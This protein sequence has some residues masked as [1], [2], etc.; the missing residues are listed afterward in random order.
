MV[1]NVAQ[2][3]AGLDEAPAADLPVL[4]VLPMLP[5]MLPMLIAESG[6]ERAAFGTGGALA[7]PLLERLARAR[8]RLG[9]ERLEAPVLVAGLLAQPAG[10]QEELIRRDPRL[11][12]WG[13]GELLLRRGEE[14]AA[15]DPAES[16]RLAGLALTTADQLDGCHPE[17]VLQDLRARAWAAVG[18]ARRQAG[19]L[20]AAEEA[21]RASAGC[22]AHGTGD[23]LVE[24]RLLEFEAAVRLDQERRGEAAALLL[25]AASRYRSVNEPELLDRVLLRRNEIRR[26]EE[27]VRFATE[28]VFEPSV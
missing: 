10:W 28:L 26:E 11:Q 1:D 2:A 15:Q 8:N 20:R 19:Q 5:P 4:P 25:Q 21:L 27:R 23:L 13:V 9:R 22:L 17:P 18:E 7:G 16:A 6:G 3:Q 12:T 24:A 14:L